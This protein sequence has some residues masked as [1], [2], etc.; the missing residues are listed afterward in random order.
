VQRPSP[1]VGG[2]T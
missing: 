2:W 1:I